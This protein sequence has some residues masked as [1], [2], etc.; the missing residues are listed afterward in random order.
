M[1]RQNQ[2]TITTFGEVLHSFCIFHLSGVSFRKFRAP[3]SDII[4]RIFPLY[5]AIAH[6]TFGSTFGSDPMKYSCTGTSQS[7]GRYGDPYG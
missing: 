6:N 3:K 7:T 1:A 5:S 4:E 2:E